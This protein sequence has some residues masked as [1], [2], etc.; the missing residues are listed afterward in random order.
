MNPWVPALEGQTLAGY[1]LD[2]GS[3][4]GGGAFGLVFEVTE[5]AT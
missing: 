1:Y 3:C 5:V 2:I 4:L